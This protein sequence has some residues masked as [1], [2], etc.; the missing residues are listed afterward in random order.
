[1][2]DLE[3]EKAYEEEWYGCAEHVASKYPEKDAFVA[4]FIRGRE[5]AV[6]ELSEM[7]EALRYAVNSLETANEIFDTDED[8]AE[9][10]KEWIEDTRA[11]FKLDEEKKG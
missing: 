8:D 1:M 5:S 9:E 4:G 6:K 3:A 10:M 7:R 11:R 2:S